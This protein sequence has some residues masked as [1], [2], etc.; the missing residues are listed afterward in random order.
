MTEIMQEE[1]IFALKQKAI[2]NACHVLLLLEL[3]L[4]ADMFVLY[5]TDD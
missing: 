3:A 1:K 5:N 2:S 4:M